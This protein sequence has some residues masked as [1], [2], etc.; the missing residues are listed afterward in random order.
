MAIE[1]GNPELLEF[2]LKNGINPNFS[3][4]TGPVNRLKEQTPLSVAKQRND[5]KA[6]GLIQQYGK[7][8]Y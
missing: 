1:R 7:N 4:V 2:L 8:T 3:F 6:I 5:R